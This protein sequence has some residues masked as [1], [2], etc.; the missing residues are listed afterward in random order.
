MFLIFQVICCSFL[1]PL[2]SLLF[3]IFLV[4]PSSKVLLTQLLPRNLIHNHRTI[5]LHTLQVRVKVSMK[6]DFWLINSFLYLF[7]LVFLLLTLRS[8]PINLQVSLQILDLV[9]SEG[10]LLFEVFPLKFIHHNN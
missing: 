4:P 2:S 9:Y 6:P 8:I 3:E 10:S 5:P 1:L 7:L